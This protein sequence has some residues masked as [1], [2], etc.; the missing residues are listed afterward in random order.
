MSNFRKCFLDFWLKIIHD[1]K[2]RLCAHVWVYPSVTVCVGGYKSVVVGL[3]SYLRLPMCICGYVCVRVLMLVYGGYVCTC[4]Y[5]S[6]CACLRIWLNI[7]TVYVCAPVSVD[8]YLYFY[9]WLC[10]HMGMYVYVVRVCV[11]LC[12]HG[13]S[14]WVRMCP[15]GL[16]WVFE[17][18]CVKTCV[19]VSLRACACVCIWLCVRMW[20]CERACICVCLCSYAGIYVRISMCVLVNFTTAQISWQFLSCS[21][22]PESSNTPLITR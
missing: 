11:Y 8:L 1:R 17:Y 2:L 18:T 22:R 6:M 15:C 21:V 13:V 7:C 10:A 14:M 3:C 9:V 19:R 16:I 5:I 20:E 12:V 4:M